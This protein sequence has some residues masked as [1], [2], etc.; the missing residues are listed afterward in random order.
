M[1]KMFAAVTLVL[2]L[3]WL[4]CVPGAILR[5]DNDGRLIVNTTDP[6]QPVLVNG[7]DVQAVQ[8]ELHELQDELQQL[9]EE[10][11]MTDTTTGQ[12]DALWSVANGHS[13]VCS[14]A[15]ERAAQLG[16]KCETQLAGGATKPWTLA[17]RFAND[18]IDTWTWNRCDLWHN[19]AL[20]GE[21]Q[22]SSD[23]K[24][25]AWLAPANDLLF[26]SNTGEWIAYENALGSQSLAALFTGLPL[27]CAS[28]CFSF[29]PTQKNIAPNANRCSDTMFANPKDSD[30]GPHQNTCGFAWGFRHNNGCPLDDVG[31]FGSFGPN[32]EER[33]VE[34]PSLGFLGGEL[35]QGMYMELYVR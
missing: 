2:A 14:V 10:Q 34:E 19:A 32:S 7:V 27:P 30:V 26:L 24:G 33:S 31:S 17:A 9:R 18:G 21:A 16:E 20:L 5:E 15:P 12:L 13:R 8:Q 4:A 3:C 1:T 6:T 22:G 35:A 11:M 29:T 25:R 28:G 23:F